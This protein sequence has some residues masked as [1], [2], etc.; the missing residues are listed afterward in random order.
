[1]A[2]K[3]KL[4]LVLKNFKRSEGAMITEIAGY[5]KKFYLQSFDKQGWGGKQWKQV[6]RR[7][8]GTPEYE[9][10]K[11]KGT[12]RRRKPILVGK[13]VLRRAVNNSVK[14]KSSS[15][16]KFQVDVPYADIHN[17]GGVMRNGKRMPK[18]QFMGWSKELNKG[19]KGIIDK[20]MINATKAN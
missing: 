13:G 14:S 2:N 8:P 11:K 17:T 15:M 9:Y 4:D 19:I 3:F 7:I 1:M 16:I 10:P 18:R 20:Y 5:A 12:A 6:R